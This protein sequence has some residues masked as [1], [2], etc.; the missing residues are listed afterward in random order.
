VYL[1]VGYE[2]LG[3]RAYDR[4]PEYAELLERSI[5]WVIGEKQRY[6]VS[7]SIGPA[8]QTGAPGDT[9]RY[10][11][12]IANSGATASIYDLALSGNT[13][14]TRVLSGTDQVGQTVEIPPCSNQN[15]TVEVDIPS[16]ANTG[17]QDILSIVA[18]SQADPAVGD[19]VSA[20]TM[21][22][23]SWETEAPMPTPR[24]RLA[25]TYQPG[26]TYF[27]AIGGI[28]GPYWDESLSSN[29]RY[30]ACSGQWEILAP[31][32]APRGN[33]AAAMIDDKIYVVGGFAASVSYDDLVIYD[34]ATDSWSSGEPLPEPLSG[35]A[36]A[37]YGDKLYAFGG[38]TGSTLSDKTYEYDPATDV[39]QEKAPMPGGGR[40]YAAAAELDGKIYV[41][42]GWTVN[43]VEI[44]DPATD[45]W[46]R[47]ASMNYA[48]QS[49][50]VTTAPDGYLYVSGGGDGW[51]GLNSAERYDPA[52]DTW[53]ILPSL[54]DSAR[55]GSVS[56]YVAGRVF[57]VGGVDARLSDINES[58]QLFDS[59]C[60]SNKRIWQNSAR[61][62]ESP[63]QKP[64]LLTLSR[65][66]DPGTQE[67]DIGT[68]MRITYTIELHGDVTTLE[69]ASVIDMI[70][71]RTTFA[72]FG[73]NTAGATY[74][75]AENQVEWN[76]TIPQDTPPLSFTF[77]IDVNLTEWSS[78]DLV[79]N[80]AS[81]D[82]GMGQVFT[83]TAATQLDFADPAASA[84]MVDQRWVMAGDT[85]TYTV[86]IQN[87]S[88]ISDTF[89]MV[90]PIP[91]MA[92]YVADSLT[93]TLGT[94]R[95]DP[96][97]KAIQ[98]TGTLPN[99]G[100]YANDSGDYQWGDSN[101]AGDV[102]GVTFEWIDIRQ[103]GVNAGGG[104][105]SY[106]CGLPID[107]PF[108][109]Y[110]NSESTFCASTNGF[111]SF[112]AE[113]TSDLTNDCPLPSPNGNK[114]IIAAL[115]DDLVVE[116]GLYYQNFGAP[117][118]R[119]LVV[120]WDGVRHYGDS[121]SFDFEVIL[122]ENGTFK[123]QILDAGPERGA[124]STTGI[125]D[126]SKNR[127]LTYACDIEDSIHD[128]LAVGFVPSGASWLIMIPSADVVFAVT[129]NTSLPVNARVTNT[130]TITGP[131]N[132]VQRS[133]DTLIN[134]V[135]LSNSRKEAT[136]HTTTG[137]RVSYH[138]S[139]ENTGLLPANSA[140]LADPIPSHTAYVPG[141]L[142]CSSGICNYTPETTMVNWGGAIES[143]SLVS[144]TF[145][146]ILVASLPDMT[147]VTN[148]ATLQDGYGGTYNLQTVSWV[149]APSLADSFKEVD[150]GTA[151]YGDALTFTVYVR[152]SG[153]ADALAEMQDV[154]PVELTY[155]P[156]SLTCG[157]G[158][159]DY[160]G[161]VITWEGTAP[162]Q[163]M[164]PIQFQATAPGDGYYARQIVNT[165]RITNRTTS[166]IHTV[167]ATV[168]LR[169]PLE[170]QVYLP[171]I[172]RD[173]R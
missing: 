50:G 112:D 166:A 33:L 147:P 76:G 81:F 142:R 170:W 55:A 107:F 103:T 115:W 157:T 23:P 12:T 150:P 137:E 60:R 51:S 69:S 131:F 70:P 9:V 37:A 135:D 122:Y 127:G 3:P 132:T 79:I 57:A 128:D 39:W 167:S 139:L 42:G 98:W 28:G 56:A 34:P 74:N 86:R 110:G 146:V 58:L 10:D 75:A 111:L 4:P 62:L 159:C 65:L 151:H 25:A 44:Y 72:G 173:A 30:N 152:N 145:D 64:A 11:L 119:Y 141:S 22:F 87:D 106:F 49:P 14:Q 48:R 83:R 17:E 126:Y 91:P 162:A 105:D 158:S 54:N 52:T 38:N 41:I 109:F 93:Y 156:A 27:Y 59:F 149:R 46:A 36:A 31:M 155:V 100:I 8:E 2:N 84:K 35:M 63:M 95:Y 97:S 138:L 32:P 168:L 172:T 82:S 94:A 160:T 130:A 40:A 26:D 104:D 154:L 117:P 71:E 19:R 88:S 66:P 68:S 96:E 125:Q 99:R 164:V 114:A 121:T 134:P 78:G 136:S 108:E 123:I 116:G 113:G 80:E 18:T 24:Y 118:N 67:Q 101:D 124:S 140:R 53:Q 144:L 45:T 161:G 129:T 85:L 13:W 153:V 143:N 120:Q 6:G 29:E 61:P 43:T 89:T 171:I 20:T 163:S 90:D 169:S 148:T 5:Q 133:T 7:V 1:G 15:L 73:D 16:L 47:A 21:A 77:G 165:A 102:P 92:G